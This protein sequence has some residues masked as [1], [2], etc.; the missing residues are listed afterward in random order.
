MSSRK[1]I[2]IVTLGCSKNIVDSEKLLKQLQS[3]GY[4]IVH[5]SEDTSAGTVIINTCGFIKDAKEESIETILQFVREKEKGNIQY[6]FVM[7]CL[8]ERYKKDLENEIPDVDKYFGSNNL[9]D[10]IKTLELNFRED[11]I[12][13]R[14]LT[15]PT[16]Y[17]YLKVSEGC[18]RKCS[19]A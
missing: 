2:N 12:G 1:K 6:L 9:P 14:L 17:A 7:G 16:H 3:G 19:G 13:E 5:D 11:L 15:S 8:S 18:N 10:I 4:S